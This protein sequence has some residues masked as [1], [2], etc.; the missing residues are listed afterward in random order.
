ML[1][2]LMYDVEEEFR[3]IGGGDPA[4]VYDEERELFRFH[5]ARFAFSRRYADWELLRKR[6]RLRG[7]E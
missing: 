3:E 4:L 7:M 5:E 6:E 2:E 1:C